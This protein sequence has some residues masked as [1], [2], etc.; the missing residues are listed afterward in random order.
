M[1]LCN[2]YLI[3]W[4]F[5][6]LLEAI[7]QSSFCLETGELFWIPTYI[8]LINVFTASIT[9]NVNRFLFFLIAAA[10]M[11]E[12]EEVLVDAETLALVLFL[13]SETLT[14]LVADSVDSVVDF[15]VPAYLSLFFFN[16]AAI[17]SD[18]LDFYDLVLVL[19]AKEICTTFLIGSSFLI[20]CSGSAARDGVS[21]G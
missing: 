3:G 21:D 20:G 16:M 13:V 8:S 7:S 12:A 11:S 2:Y 9:F 6:L 15:A 14:V 5:S 1:E 10:I 18:Y 19:A 4:V 17:I